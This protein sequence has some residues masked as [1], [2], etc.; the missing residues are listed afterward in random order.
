MTFYGESYGSLPLP[1]RATLAVRIRIV[2]AAMRAF[3]NVIEHIRINDGARYLVRAAR[4]LPKID[5]PA[6]VAAKREGF[7]GAQNDGAAGRATKMRNVLF[8]HKRT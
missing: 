3:S 5:Q 1:S 2:V 8:R 7:L 6:A 4:P